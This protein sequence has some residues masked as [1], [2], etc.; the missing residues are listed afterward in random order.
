[1]EIMTKD[2]N[3]C[4]YIKELTAFFVKGDECTPA[5]HGNICEHHI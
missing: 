5:G 3:G 4:K 2:C 1:M